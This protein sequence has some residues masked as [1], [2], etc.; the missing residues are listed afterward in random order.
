MPHSFRTE[1]SAGE[2]QDRMMFGERN[3]AHPS[4][5]LKY[6]FL[7]TFQSS[8]SSRFRQGRRV[9]ANRATLA[10]TSGTTCPISLSNIIVALKDFSVRGYPAPPTRAGHRPRPPQD[11]AGQQRMLAI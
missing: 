11:H 5:S 2:T 1:I 7:H 8:I 4:F 9:V 10:P 3:C 6:Q